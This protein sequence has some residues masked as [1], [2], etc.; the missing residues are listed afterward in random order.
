MQRK[1]NLNVRLDEVEIRILDR[2]KEVSGFEHRSDSIRQCIRL[3]N[4]IFDPRLTIK[5]AF[6]PEIWDM[7]MEN[8]EVQDKMPLCYALKKIPVLERELYG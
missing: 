1:Y 7:I 3:A 8:K 5:K 4:V 2:I 6:I